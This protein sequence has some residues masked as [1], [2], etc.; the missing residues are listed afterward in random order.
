[1][2]HLKDY[3]AFNEG[4]YKEIVSEKNQFIKEQLEIN[5]LQ[6]KY[7]DWEK[8]LIKAWGGVLYLGYHNLPNTL[9]NLVDYNR[10]KQT[11][12]EYFKESDD[13]EDMQDWMSDTP[14]TLDKGKYSLFDKNRIDKA[15]TEIANKTIIT[16]ELTIYRTS[17]NYLP[18]WNSYT[19]RN[20]NSYAYKNS[21]TISY[22]LPI[23]FPV[24]FADGIADNDEVIVKLTEQNMS[25]FKQHTTFNEGFRGLLHGAS[26]EAIARDT[27]ESDNGYILQK[28]LKNKKI[29]LADFAK[30]NKQFYKLYKKDIDNINSIDTKRLNQLYDLVFKTNNK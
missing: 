28:Q 4:F 20:D 27:E 6:N 29:K 22:K 7:E 30:S 17:D 15:F 3:T 16:E 21:S 23:G 18:E 5:K 8:G 25:D 24:I 2:N 9:N 26:K 12:L 13:N 14:P 11:M 1:M 10:F 19:L